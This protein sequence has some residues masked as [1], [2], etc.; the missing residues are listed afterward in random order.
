[1]VL[2]HSLSRL[3]RG[4]ALAC[5]L[6][7][8]FISVAAL[9]SPASAQDALASNYESDPN[10]RM[11]L[12]ADE[13]V[14]DRDI[15]TVTAQGKV[16]IEYDGN[17]LVADKVT[18][19]QQTRR[20]TATG[21]V[22]IV[23]RDGN[24][25]YSEHMDV[26]DSFRDGFVNGLRVETT[27]NTRFAAESAER[28]NGEITTF[29]NGVYT[30]CEPCAKNP[31]KPVLWQIKA[32]K[33]IWNST[34]KTVRFEHGRFEFFGMPLAYFPAFEMADPTVKRKSGFLF[35][36]FSYKD[37]LGVG[38]KNSYFWALAPNYDVT[39]STTA[40][41]KQGFLTEAEWR[42]RLENGTYNL[43]IAGI[44]QNKPGEFDVNTVDREED[45][46]GM[47]ASKGDFNLNSRWRFGW[48][49][50]AQTDRN[51]SRT[52][53]LDGY[54]AETQVS[55]IYLTG[56]NNRNY[57]DLN[58]YRFNVQESLL[59]DN[60]N[61][62]H[63]KQP[64]V[65]PSL[66]YS[67]TMPEPVYG[68]ELNF[69]T[70]LQVLY[71]QNANYT[72]L[73]TRFPRVPGFDGTNARLT[74]EAEWKRTFITPAGLVI[75]PLLALRGD[76][77]GANTNFNLADAGYTD[78]LVRSEALRAMAT[79]GLELRWPI[80]FSTTSSTHIIEPIAQL[81]VRNNERYAGELPNE[82]AQSF[83]FDATNLFSRDKFSGY[84][85]VEGGT[86]ANLG[87]RYSGN[88]NN[89]DWALY[90]L[91]GQ[92]FQLGGVNSYGTSDFVNV[93]ADSGL[94]D[95]RSDYVAMIGTSNSTGLALAARGRF[96]KDSFAVQ[97]GELEAQQSWQKLTVSAQYAYIAPQPAYGYSDLRQEVT[98][99]ATA[100]INT[101]WRVFGSGTYDMVSETLVRASS[102][103]A[104]DD[105]CFTYSMAYVQTRN[106]GDDKASHSVGFNISLRTL[107]DIGSGNQTF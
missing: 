6:A 24:K 52:Y 107:G 94:Q 79:A 67:Y 18:Y 74:T 48:D 11:L 5:V 41:T 96:D 78:A 51:F 34:T 61:E 43:R 40:Y 30:A 14:Y 45:N 28:S 8:P 47:V 25:I 15:N 55:K 85:R 100:R 97:R 76:A 62:M 12:Q 3:A 71:R 32:H 80:L 98:G 59:S 17:H 35:P 77:I 33:I 49:V 26:T 88:F 95:A 21:N 63:S 38:I 2:P 56:I 10:A 58:F 68:G 46:R 75:T 57:F 87:V 91:G 73:G 1:M 44:H 54:G 83:V 23:E 82:D 72:P 104:Y 16:R 9:P 106:P 31:D 37:D 86:R 105:E 70:N 92:S 93:G 64:W 29:N 20:M 27:D 84:D 102:G 36:G 4:T 65:F 66:D 99:S 69:N 60:P 89:S 81:Y 103:L 50:M 7:L 39:L 53:S 90:A 22:E 42:H 101:N 13:L 19:N